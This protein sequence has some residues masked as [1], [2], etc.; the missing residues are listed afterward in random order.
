MN[1]AARRR[2]IKGG[3]AKVSVFVVSA[4][5]PIS[6][7]LGECRLHRRDHP[8]R[9]GD[10]SLDIPKRLPQAVEAV[11]SSG[12]QIMP[13]PD[14]RRCLC[15][16]LSLPACPTL[17]PPKIV[18]ILGGRGAGPPPGAKRGGGGAYALLYFVA[19][20]VGHQ[21]L[22]PAAFPLESY[23]RG[24]SPALRDVVITHCFFLVPFSVLLWGMFIR[25]SS[26]LSIRSHGDLAAAVLLFFNCAADLSFPRPTPAD[27]QAAVLKTPRARFFTWIASIILCA[28]YL[29]ACV[30]ITA[31]AVKKLLRSFGGRVASPGRPALLDGAGL[32]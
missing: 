3:A 18:L 4:V 16:W 2:P 23:C 31:S 14:G 30:S 7:C 10:L 9:N 19:V 25:R 12:G 15:S 5:R 8:A 26:H 27:W 29:S 17:A 13:P 20:G 22:C 28:S 21:R 24:G 32:P 6:L 11:A 1:V